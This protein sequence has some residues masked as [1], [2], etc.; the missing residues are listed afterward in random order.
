MFVRADLERYTVLKKTYALSSRRV[1]RRAEWH[2][3]RPAD[4]TMRVQSVLVD[5]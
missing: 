3:A 2:D 4:N 1:F 5:R